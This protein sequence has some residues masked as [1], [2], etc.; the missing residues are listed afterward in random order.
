VNVRAKILLRS[1]IHLLA[2]GETASLNKFRRQLAPLIG[3]RE[4]SKNSSFWER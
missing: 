3:L 1:G 2:F 4:P